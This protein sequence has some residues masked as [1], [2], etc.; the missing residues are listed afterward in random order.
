MTR[1]RNKMNASQVKGKSKPGRQ[2][3]G[4]GLYLHT[5]KTGTKSWVFVWTRKGRKREMGLG[6]ALDVKLQDARKKAEKCRH[7][8]DQG[9]DPI[10]ERDKQ[11]EP[12]FLE[13]ATIYLEAHEPKWKNEK[14]IYQW[15]QSLFEHAKPIHNLRVS[16]I[17]TSDI[18]QIL[19]P[20]WLS[21]YETANRTRGRLES[22]LLYTSPSP[23]DGLL[24]RMPS[25]A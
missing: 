2:S 11:N 18:L 13:C 1:A 19:K 22:C 8:I 3:D 5:S 24:S 23:R 14:H 7:Q 12:T 4:G 6:S 16:Q 25:S 17:S 9:L 15:R 21:K 20:I 10:I